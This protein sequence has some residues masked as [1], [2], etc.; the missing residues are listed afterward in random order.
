MSVTVFKN[1][2]K[3]QWKLLLIFLCVLCFY[4]VVVIS[5]IDPD[6]MAKVQ[7]IFGSMEEY[8][9]IFSISIPVAYSSIL[10]SSIPPR[11]RKKGLSVSSGRNTANSTALNP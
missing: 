8:M 1:T 2:W 9:S 5:L 3:R 4:Q 7:E 10:A 11:N 6:D